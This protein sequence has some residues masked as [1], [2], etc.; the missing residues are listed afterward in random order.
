MEKYTIS[1]IS[2]YISYSSYT[3]VQVLVLVQ[4]RSDSVSWHSHY[5][6]RSCSW[7]SVNIC[8]AGLMK[9]ENQVTRSI[10]FHPLI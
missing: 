8:L 5:V 2:W 9:D 10:L 4:M 1:I 3:E 6:M 7:G